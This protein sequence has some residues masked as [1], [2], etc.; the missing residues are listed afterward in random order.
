M[1]APRH[2]TFKLVTAQGHRVTKDNEVVCRT[3]SDFR[4]YGSRTDNSA[5]L[6]IAMH[7]VARSMH[8]LYTRDRLH[9]GPSATEP[10]ILTIKCWLNGTEAVPAEAGE[11]EDGSNAVLFEAE[12]PPDAALARA[13]GAV[14]AC[15]TQ[16]A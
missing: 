13:L 2:P 7:A 15:I 16:M 14:T 3:E 1:S 4:F 6:L 11:E 10:D 5:T 12:K 8:N 9:A